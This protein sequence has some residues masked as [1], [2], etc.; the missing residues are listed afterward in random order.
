MT[1]TN[2]IKDTNVP[3]L[4]FNVYDGQVDEEAVMMEVQS[5]RKEF[6]VEYYGIDKTEH[7]FRPLLQDTSPSSLS[8]CLTTGATVSTLCFAMS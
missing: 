3:P 7:L 8:K 2:T 1:K 5:G 6:I 4:S